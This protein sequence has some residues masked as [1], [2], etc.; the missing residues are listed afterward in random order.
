M[1]EANDY[2]GIEIERNRSRGTIRLTQE[3][4]FRG[5]LNRFDFNYYP[6]KDVP[7]RDGTRFDPDDTDFLTDEKKHE[8]QSQVGS[9]TYGMQGTRPDIA[10]PVTLLSRFLA[11]PTTSQRKA[12]KH[13]FQYILKTLSYGITYDRHDTR[14]LYGYT[15]SDW[16]GTTL[17]EKSRSTS[18]YAFYLAGGLIS[19]SSKRQT[20]VALSSTNAEYIGQANAVRH[21]VHLI[22]FLGELSKPPT[23]PITIYT[24][25]MSAR[26]LALNPEYHS[27]AKHIQL[28]FHFQREKIE[29]DQ[30]KFEHVSTENQVADGFTK[31]LGRIKHERFVEMLGLK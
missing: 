1:T 26:A 23:L 7:L 8:Y 3:K 6:P 14:G 18:G 30:V 28:V 21:A 13:V 20:T 16:A 9:L 12:L 5:L 31:P 10:Y 15:D 2:L 25:N 19:W 24:D 29:D 4:Y 17:P 11:K 27:K 22:Q